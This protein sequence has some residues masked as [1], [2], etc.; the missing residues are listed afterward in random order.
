MASLVISVGKEAQ[1][2]WTIEL[3]QLKGDEG[4]GACLPY[5]SFKHIMLPNINKVFS[6]TVTALELIFF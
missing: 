4:E 1:E 5:N 2:A 6:Y 3:L